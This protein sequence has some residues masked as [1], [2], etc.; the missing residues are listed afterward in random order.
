[1]P[2]IESIDTSNPV[3]AALEG[4]EY[5]DYGLLTKPTVNMNM[6]FEWENFDLVEY[7][8]DKMGLVESNVKKFKKINNLE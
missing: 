2:F 4:M 1:M 8:L 7:A 3:M 5:K 6:A